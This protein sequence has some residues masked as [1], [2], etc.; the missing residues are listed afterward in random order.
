M[1][2]LVLNGSSRGA[3]GV[4]G[5]MLAKLVKGLKEG[6]ADI[7]E[8]QLRDL[9]ISH[10]TA[11]MACMHKTPG[12]CV[13]NDDMQ[14]LYAE[15]KQANLLVIGS[16]V[17][18]DT[19]SGLMKTV[20]DRSMC[21]MEPFFH[22]D[23][24][25][26]VRHTFVWKMPESFFLVSTCGFPE[27]ENFAPI[28]ATYKAQAATFGCEAIGELCIPGSIALQTAPQY[29]EARYEGIRE[30]GRQ[31][32][33]KGRVAEDLLAELNKPPFDRETYLAV[34]AKYEEWCRQNRTP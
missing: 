26:R 32:A 5:K 28:I 19:E 15:L 14:T 34:V 20:I 31:L 8:F 23:E 6:G 7:A 4:T 10:C 11:C 25:G 21:C 17:Y 24:G 33:A 30:A 9:T 12:A 22:V 1:K 18:T 16:P 29:L 27:Y 2:A 3:R 13:L